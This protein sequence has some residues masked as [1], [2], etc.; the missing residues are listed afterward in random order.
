MEKIDG[1]SS[2]RAALE[3]T[4][5]TGKEN[6]LRVDNRLLSGFAGGY[7]DCDPVELGGGSDKLPS[8]SGSPSSSNSEGGGSIIL[9]REESRE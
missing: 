2:S 1:V 9:I 3:L 8:G 6:A 7:P 5:R 4:A